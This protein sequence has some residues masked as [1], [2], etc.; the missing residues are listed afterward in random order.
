[1]LKHVTMA[2][3]ISLLCHSSSG[4]TKS[5]YFHCQILKMNVVSPINLLVDLQNNNLLGLVNLQNNNLLGLVNLHN[6][7]LLGLMISPMKLWTINVLSSRVVTNFSKPHN[8][9]T[10]LTSCREER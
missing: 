9:S 3:P 6:N 2:I 1:M 8:D 7:N 5:S 10:S 4:A